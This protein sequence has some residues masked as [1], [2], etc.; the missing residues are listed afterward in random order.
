[1][2][3]PPFPPSH[4]HM[5]IP[6]LPPSHSHMYTQRTY[7]QLFGPYCMQLGEMS[8]VLAES[9][10][11]TT[12][13]SGWQRTILLMHLTKPRSAASHTI[14]WG[15]IDTVDCSRTCIFLCFHCAHTIGVDYFVWQ[16]FRGP[17]TSMYY[18]NISQGKFS[19]PYVNVICNTLNM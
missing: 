4:S 10:P 7:R 18:T 9:Y 8:G 19:R 17:A 14:F 13:N 6:P 15:N 16:L 1:M 11:P 12:T 5:H 2:H 3:I